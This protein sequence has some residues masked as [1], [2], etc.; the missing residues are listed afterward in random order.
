MHPTGNFRRCFVIPSEALPLLHAQLAWPV[1]LDVSYQQ[2]PL[3]AQCHI[4]LPNQFFQSRFEPAS[5]SQ[6]HCEVLQD[7]NKHQPKESQGEPRKLT[8]QCHESCRRIP[9]L[10][11]FWTLH[12]DFRRE[13]ALLSKRAVQTATE[14]ANGG[15]YAQLTDQVINPVL[16]LP[17]RML[18]RQESCGVRFS[19]R[20]FP[21]WYCRSYSIF[22]ESHVGCD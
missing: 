18:A 2:V 10:S 14:D 4:F 15:F 8:S 5:G 17:M 1:S 20:L 19:G 7:Q 9:S 21:Y 22:A 3:Q 13:N 6:R 12:C 11:H 16:A